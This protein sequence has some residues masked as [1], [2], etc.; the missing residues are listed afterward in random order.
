M[1]AKLCGVLSQHSGVDLDTGEKE[2]V[3]AAAATATGSLT[4]WNNLAAVM[5]VWIT[6]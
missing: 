4:Y 5:A 1:P 3:A 6:P 2:Q